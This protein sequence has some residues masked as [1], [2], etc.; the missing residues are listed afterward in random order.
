VPGTYAPKEE[1]FAMAAAVRDGGGGVFQMACEHSDVPTELSMMQTLSETYGLPVMFN[2]SQFDQSPELWRDV[3][4]QLAAINE[5]PASVHGQVAGR[6]IGIVM[7]LQSTAHPF[8]LKPSW[9]Q[10]YHSGWEVQW[11]ALQDAEFRQKLMDEESIFMGDFEAFVTS[12]FDKM[13]L[14]SDG[15]EPRP[16]QSIAAQAAATGR[17]PE[18]IAMQTLL[19]HDGQGMLYFPLFNYSQGSLD[20]LHQLHQSEHTR[21]GLSDAGAH[22]GSICDGGMPTFMLTHWTRDRTRGELLPLEWVIHRQTQQTAQSFGLLDRGLL[23]PG[24]RADI[25]VIDYDNLRLQR[26]RL[27]WDLPAGGRRLIQ[28][29]EGYRATFKGGVAISENDTPTGAL[30]GRLVRGRRSAPAN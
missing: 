19:Q 27:V 8:A 26:P 17:R 6:A 3:M 14:V 25:N 21:M 5:G 30:P 18:E 16:E 7:A 2:L 12:S 24:Y 22:C 15:Y 29:A 1:L 4:G 13:F 9:L 23:K 11:A 20:V 10:L 28:R